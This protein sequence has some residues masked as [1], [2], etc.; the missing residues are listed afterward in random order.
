[1]VLYM[2]IMHPTLPLTLYIHIAMYHSPLFSPSYRQKNYVYLDL[3]VEMVIIL[4]QEQML[5]NR[6][7]G[8]KAHQN[9]G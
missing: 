7:R 5:V 1:M 8:A 9:L 4:R 3:S 6:E 2:Y